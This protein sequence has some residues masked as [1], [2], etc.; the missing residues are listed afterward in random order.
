[1]TR[2]DLDPYLI[3]TLAQRTSTEYEGLCLVVRFGY[4][5]SIA[6]KTPP[7]TLPSPC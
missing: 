4:R 1:M 2:N 6:L 5:P 7:S 3:E